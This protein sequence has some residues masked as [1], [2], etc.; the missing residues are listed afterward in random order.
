MPGTRSRFD[1]KVTCAAPDAQSAF[2]EPARKGRRRRAAAA[3]SGRARVAPRGD[4][5]GTR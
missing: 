1:T 2:R 4:A 3:G 5:E